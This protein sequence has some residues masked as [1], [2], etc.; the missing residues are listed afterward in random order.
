M[1]QRAVQ[2]EMNLLSLLAPWSGQLSRAQ[3]RP[4]CCV[5]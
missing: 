3:S 1:R 5:L 2:P 4:V